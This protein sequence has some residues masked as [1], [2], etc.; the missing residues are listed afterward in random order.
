MG[1]V[2]AKAARFS[3]PIDYMGAMPVNAMRFVLAGAVLLVP[4][5]SLASELD[6]KSGQLRF[7]SDAVKTWSFESTD[8]LING[9]ISAIRYDSSG[10]RRTVTKVTA[11][12]QLDGALTTAAADALEGQRALRIGG[13][14]PASSQGFALTD[15]TLF[16]TLGGARVEV[17][18]W[19]RADGGTPSFAVAYGKPDWTTNTALSFAIAPSTR[20]GR[21]TS[22]GWVEYT[23]GPIDGSVWGVP[24]QAIT[25]M[26][27]RGATFL[28]D[29]V[30]LKKLSGAI[31][32]NVA[33]TT[34]NVDS[35]C[36]EDGDCIYGRCVSSSV[37]WGALPSGGHRAE[38]AARFS[39]LASRLIGD[40]ASSEFGLKT[41]T[42][43]ARELASYARS[44]RKF[45][46]GINR[47]V[48]GLRDNHTS[49]GAP[50]TESTTFGPTLSYGW[51]AGL[52]A[53]FGVIEKDL[54]GGGLG[55]GVFRAGSKP[56]T[57][58]ALKPGDLLTSIDGI[59]AK[60]WAD[61]LFPGVNRTSPNDPSSDW[62]SQAESLALAI[63]MYAREI[64]VTRCATAT[65]C[66]G[67]NKAE[68][69]IPVAE[70]I[71]AH[72]L[73]NGGWGADVAGYGCSSRFT[74][75]VV[76]PPRMDGEG[77]PHGMGDSVNSA[78]KDGI[79]N[80]SFDGFS[81]QAPW[82]DAMTAVFDPKP[83]RVLMDARVGNGGTGDNVETLLNLLR[84][85]DE[86][87]GFITVVNGT[88]DTPSPSTLFNTYEKCVGSGGGGGA[89]S[90]FGAW[91][92]FSEL[93]TPPGARTKLAWLNT[94]DVSA[95]D[96]MPRLLKGRGAL[97]IFAPHPTSG[98]FGAI[99]EVL[100][101]T[102]GWSGG[103]I[104]YQDSRFGASYAA[105]SAARWESGHGV[106]PDV[107]VAQKVSDAILGKDTMLEA[108]RAWLK[109]E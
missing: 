107:V 75:S 20:T 88:Y 46:G 41:F 83:A 82:K 49:M 109:A 92:F 73:E 4:T 2:A 22:D 55:F 53:C 13:A 81:G 80:V 87:I 70:K 95:N 100:S 30:E 57:G 104:Q 66:A 32:P 52:D 7:A 99:T 43:A 6:A 40:R 78:T 26:P 85:K 77:S 54:T 33:C 67:A 69:V 48:N 105:F 3:P 79:V 16:K 68:I 42:P 21:E 24:I 63:S 8:A 97:R 101:F 103:S 61:A 28:V 59:D 94:R 62:A 50:A 84:G 36:G 65:D 76:P 29:A 64:T 9:S 89:F 23:T 90:C 31:T 38:L 72:I 14:T 17:S 5:L 34:A 25:F 98:A 51:A 39:H 44:S 56:V 106:E 15:E 93:D 10:Y 45:F 18:M 37:T 74:E 1:V 86:Q 60:K 58:V 35:V 47:L 96:Y 71:F 27:P 108:A 102:P 12:T 11:A 91:G 19:A